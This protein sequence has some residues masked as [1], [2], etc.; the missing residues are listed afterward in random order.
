M[1]YDG[2]TYMPRSRKL[3]LSVAENN[4]GLVEQNTILRMMPDTILKMKILL[5]GSID[6]SS[7]HPALSSFGNPL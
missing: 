5:Q 6:Y 7:L 3:S 1:G 4:S 2:I